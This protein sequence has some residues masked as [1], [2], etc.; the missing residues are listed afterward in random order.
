MVFFWC[1]KRHIDVGFEALTYLFL[2]VSVLHTVSWTG[3]FY[4][5]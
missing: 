2:A 1:I 4:G 5:E 3:C